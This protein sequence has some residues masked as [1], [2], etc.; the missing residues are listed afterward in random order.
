LSPNIEINSIFI[1]Y[2]FGYYKY[3]DN[4]IANK[5]S[6]A[7]PSQSSTMHG[8]SIK[9]QSPL[10]DT[11]VSYLELTKMLNQLLGNYILMECRMM[12]LHFDGV[13]DSPTA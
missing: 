6:C 3:L 8:D 13:P 7:A 2:I 1:V 5:D 9:Y 4:A 10:E 12:K 11:Q